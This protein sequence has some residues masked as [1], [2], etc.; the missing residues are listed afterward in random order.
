MNRRSLLA[1]LVGATGTM[2][3]PGSAISWYWHPQ[4]VHEGRVRARFASWRQAMARDSATLLSS[5]EPHIKRWR[6][7]MLAIH[8]GQTYESLDAVNRTVNGLVRY[9]DD[10]AHYHERDVWSRVSKTLIEGG[11]CEDYALTKSATLHFL[12]WPNERLH[13]LVGYIDRGRGREAHAILAAEAPGRQIWLLDNLTSLILP[14]RRSFFDP[15]YAVDDA[16]VW[17]FRSG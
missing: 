1:G 4:I 6:E 13:L 10:Y 5:T 14:P 11:D 17:L 2:A 7:A 12:G 9:I 8:R 16:H 15:V 3:V